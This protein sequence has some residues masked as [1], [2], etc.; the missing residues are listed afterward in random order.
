MAVAD[1]HYNVLI[2]K[3]CTIALW[4]CAQNNNM[5]HKAKLESQ[6]SIAADRQS[7]S[8][9]ISWKSLLYWQQETTCFPKA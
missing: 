2:E 6:V 8:L 9:Q 4:I 3:A 1:S 7:L 5:Y